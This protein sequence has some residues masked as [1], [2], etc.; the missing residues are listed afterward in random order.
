MA[1]LLSVGAGAQTSESRPFRFA[2]AGGPLLPSKIPLV[3][4]ILMGLDLRGT[5]PTSKG[6]FEVDGYF[7]QGDGTVYRSGSFEYH[8][9]FPDDVFPAFFAVGLHTDFYDTSDDVH[10][11]A[12]GWQIGGG[13]LQPLTGALALREDF[14]YRSGPG[15]SLTVLVGLSVTIL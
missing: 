10:H 12:G 7:A 15:R 4:E 2:V 6:T 3:T 11:F 1:F 8:V 13:L 14:R 5:L 9:D